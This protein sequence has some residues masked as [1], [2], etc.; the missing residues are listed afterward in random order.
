MSNAYF[1]LV[2]N[3]IW[4]TISLQCANDWRKS[5]AF[6]WLIL[7][8]YYYQNPDL[9]LP[10]IALGRRSR[11][12]FSRPLGFFTPCDFEWISDFDTEGKK[13][14]GFPF[15]P[16]DVLRNLSTSVLFSSDW[17]W[18]DISKIRFQH[19]QSV[20]DFLLCLEKFS[21]RASLPKKNPFIFPSS[22]LLRENIVW[23]CAQISSTSARIKSTSAQISSTSVQ[24]SPTFETSLVY[25]SNRNEIRKKEWLFWPILD[26]PFLRTERRR[27]MYLCDWRR[28]T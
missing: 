20:A 14:V 28:R 5:R 15:G 17:R 19:I 26:L 12:K 3:V 6:L 13:I 22:S 21:I 8:F 11:R 24:T 16:F 25:L 27:R 2:E 18:E 4:F 9:P 1:G 10:V 7:F 23:F